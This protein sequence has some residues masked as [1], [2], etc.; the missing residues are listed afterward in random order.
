MSD[1]SITR[2]NAQRSVECM[3]RGRITIFG[4]FMNIVLMISMIAI[5]TIIPHGWGILA[6]ACCG[7][8]CLVANKYVGGEI[9]EQDS[10]VA[11][12]DNCL[13]EARWASEVNQD[14]PAIVK[15][16]STGSWSEVYAFFYAFN[17]AWIVLF[18]CKYVLL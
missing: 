17:I 14:A 18:I 16:R 1:V 9:V 15:P 4:I 5:A 12:L 8:F 3:I 2:L 11:L 13:I 6:I 10:R 7:V